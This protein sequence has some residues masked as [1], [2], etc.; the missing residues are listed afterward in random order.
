MKH[1]QVIIIGGGPAGAVCAWKLVQA[2]VDCLVLDKK[3]FPRSK[4]CAGWITPQVLQKLQINA[5]DYPHGLTTFPFLKIFL[6][7]FPIIRPGRQYAIRRVEFDHWLLKRSGAP[8]I[9]HE[10]KK[11]TLVDR[12]Y[13]ID[14]K[15]SAEFLVGAG[16]THCPVYHTFFSNKP[17]TGAQIV[18]LEEEFPADWTDGSCRLWFFENGLPGYA[19]YVPKVGGY[20]NIGVGG[21]AVVLKE[22]GSNIQ[23]HWEYLVKSLQEKGLVSERDFHPEGYVYYLR[24]SQ[25]QFQRGNIFLVGDSIGLATLDMGEGIGPAIQS[26]LNAAESILGRKEYSISDIHK[27]SLLPSFLK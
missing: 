11:I 21:S 1:H 13:S 17:R 27:Y 7:G 20:L 16:G 10:V 5:G 4:T 2:G 26:G 23:D 9:P 25:D 22:K 8:V 6:K 15:Y 19:W 14:G 24:G 18:A 3:L 12:G